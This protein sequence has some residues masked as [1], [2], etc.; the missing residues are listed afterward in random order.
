MKK[1][2]LYLLLSAPL[3]LGFLSCKD[4]YDR[5]YKKLNIDKFDLSDGVAVTGGKYWKD[6]YTDNTNVESGIFKFSHT[7]LS[8]TVFDGF[9]VSNVANNSDHSGSGWYPGN[10]FAAM[11][12][13]GLSGEGKPYLVNYG[14]GLV[15]GSRITEPLKGKTFSE[16]DF[17]SWVKIQSGKKRY[18]AHRIS[19]TNTS[20]VYYTIMNGNNNGA[21]AFQNG[22]YF[23]LNIYGV[24]GDMKITAPVT[25]YLADYRDG[26]TS[27]LDKWQTI[28][29]S[30]LGDVRYIFFTLESSDNSAT[31][32]NTPAYFCID[33][34]T[35]YDRKYEWEFFD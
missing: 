3:L 35:V 7:T 10:Q 29:I 6:A 30:S 2:Y 19:V 25:V 12:K 16:Y 23:K 28:N 14:K 22:D 5:E 1:I 21:S 32:M 9:V 24:D 31:R 18:R 27:I 17:T 15:E 33:R 34:L 11:P 8:S 4:D 20:L 13:G 26:K